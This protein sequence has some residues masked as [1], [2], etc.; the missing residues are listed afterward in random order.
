MFN[1]ASIEALLALKLWIK[2]SSSNTS[3]LKILRMLEYF[4]SRLIPSSRYSLFESLKVIH[5][6]NIFTIG[7]RI[8]TTNFAQVSP[9]IKYNLLY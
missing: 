4:V 6:T 3:C 9:F 1:E 2:N 8:S 5:P 7:G